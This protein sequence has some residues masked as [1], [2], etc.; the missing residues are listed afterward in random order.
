MNR[1][2]H[3]EWCK[4]RALEYNDV[5]NVWLSMTSDIQKHKETKGHTAIELGMMLIISGNLSALAEMRE[6]I[7][8][9]Q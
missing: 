1:Q 8:G 4:E 2:E 5:K 7:E 6:F 3:L 9:F